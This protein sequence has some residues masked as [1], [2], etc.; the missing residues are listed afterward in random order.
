[1]PLQNPSLRLQVP[2]LAF[3]VR[4]RTRGFGELKIFHCDPVLERDQAL[5][6]PLLVP[7]IDEELKEVPTETPTP[8][9]GLDEE[10]AESLDRD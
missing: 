2:E 4:Q 6:D 5:L 1:L 7:E 8:K 9:L 10:A 3:Q